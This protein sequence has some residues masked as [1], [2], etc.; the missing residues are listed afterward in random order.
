M[1]ARALA[2]L[3]INQVT[4][5]GRSLTD[6]LAAAVPRLT[7]ASER[8]LLHELCYGVLRYYFALAEQAQS[9]LHKPVKRKDSDLHALLLVGLYQLAYMRVAPHAAVSMTVAAAEELDKGWAKG[10]V[11]AVLR[12]AQ[13][14]GAAASFAAHHNHPDWALAMLQNDWPEDWPAIVAANNA[15]APMAL[16][17]N[18]L[19]TSRDDYRRLLAEQGIAAEISPFAPDALIL[20][21]PMDVLEL[22]QFAQGWV[23]VQDVGAQLAAAL[24][25]ARPGERILD[26]CAAPG[27]KTAHVLELT[28]NQSQVTAL[29]ID[30]RRLDRVRDNLRRLG[31]AAQ[32]VAA[33]AGALDSWWDGVPFDR[34]LIDAPC[35]ATGVIRRHPDI[36]LLRRAADITEMAVRQSQLLRALWRVLAPGGTLLYVTCSVL[37]QENDA[38]ISALLAD[39]ADA[40]LGSLTAQW[41]R[42]TLCGRQILPGDA[43]M[44]GFFYARLTKGS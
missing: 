22:P 7:E 21:A 26:A 19:K 35:S 14:A 16:R 31:L 3:T 2:A 17:V 23:S 5:Q 28:T 38:V 20:S 33:D 43:A 25:E 30:V 37:R 10:L 18:R 12:G 8:G 27:G 13:R 42:P 11:N 1:H 39:H 6:A 4:E 9:L 29:D 36:K 24:L 15:R 41:G 44:D 32:C 40:R 34:V